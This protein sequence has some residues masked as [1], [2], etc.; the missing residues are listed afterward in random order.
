MQVPSESVRDILDFLGDP[1]LPREQSHTVLNLVA[2]TWVAEV[3]KHLTPAFEVLRLIEQEERFHV[4]RAEPRPVPLLLLRRIEELVWAISS[5]PQ[6]LIAADRF[7]DASQMGLTACAAH[8]EACKRIGM[9]PGSKIREIE[10]SCR[11]AK[12][13]AGE[14][15]E[16]LDLSPWETTRLR[17]FPGVSPMLG[18]Q[19]AT[20]R[21]K[22][23]VLI[24]AEVVRAV[25]LAI[26]RSRKVTRGGKLYRPPAVMVGVRRMYGHRAITNV[27]IEDGHTMTTAEVAGNISRKL[28]RQ[29]QKPYR[30]LAEIPDELVPLLPPSRCAAVVTNCLAMGDQHYGWSPLSDLEGVPI[31][32]SICRRD[33][34]VG[35]HVTYDHRCGDGE[36]MAVFGERVARELAG[37]GEKGEERLPLEVAS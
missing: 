16:Q 7:C 28:K 25:S 8:A 4:E 29:R 18:Y 23:S 24:E 5:D 2:E 34:G 36:D 21:E 33:G 17:A 35:L 26:E 14:V 9:E 15:P 6:F 19:A 32:V 1:R 11:A 3:F 37:Q 12:V 20:P 13:L 10:A 31:A 27:Y 30:T 22:R